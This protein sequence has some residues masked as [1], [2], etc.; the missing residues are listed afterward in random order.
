MRGKAP[1]SVPGMGISAPRSVVAMP[2][3]PAPQ[4]AGAA[5]K[6]ILPGFALAPMLKPNSRGSYRRSFDTAPT[7]VLSPL[8][9]ALNR[10]RS[11]MIPGAKDFLPKRNELSCLGQS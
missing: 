2:T 10:L 3:F 7:R 1:R 9:A 5:F 8:N 11:R 6:T 4:A